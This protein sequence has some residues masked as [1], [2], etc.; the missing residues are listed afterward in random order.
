MRYLKTYEEIS[1]KDIEYIQKDFDDYFTISF[2]FEIETSD[3]SN[4]KYKF[5]DVDEDFVDD[6][7]EVVIKEMKIKNESDKDFLEEILYDF[8]DRCEYGDMTKNKF[9]K[10][11]NHGNY[12][13][14][15]SLII[16][17]AKDV[18]TS[19]IYEEDYE[20]L[21]NK[22]KEHLPNFYEKWKTH[23]NF[24][25]DATL[26][27]GIE[28]ILKTYLSSL[29]LSI[30]MIKDF[31]DDLEKQSYWFLSEK[32]GIHI[33]IGTNKNTNWNPIKGLVLLNDFTDK[34]KTPFVFKDMTW[35]MNNHFCGSLIPYFKSLS[36]REKVTLR[37]IDL[38]DLERSEK[39]LNDFITYKI[40]KVG[41]KSFG[42]N[43]TKLEDSYVEFRYVGGVVGLNI[44]IEKFKYF[45]FIVY[46][47]SNHEYKR[48]E[49]LK[50]LYK[51]VTDFL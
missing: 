21:E 1:P 23:I 28:I 26:D 5:R 19:N 37:E 47:M 16:K 3:M 10:L 29:T 27:R 15:R 11:F 4:M 7:L 24:V 14:D 46:A 39:I 49:Y 38:K 44:L 34:D 13:G 43:I 12:E 9:E 25:G 2:E 36:K 20:Y 40:K 45:C 32:T 31:Y 42:F 17:H 22:V 48:K 50:K 8:L 6:I 18:I 35:R 33:N 30:D 51:F 41:V